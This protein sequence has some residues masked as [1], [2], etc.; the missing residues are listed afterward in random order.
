MATIVP[1]RILLL[2]EHTAALDPR[3]AKLIVELSNACIRDAKLTALMGNSQ[4]AATL[5]CGD[6]TIMMSE[7]QIAFDVRS[8]ERVVYDMP[9]LLRLFERTKG[10]PPDDDALLL[11]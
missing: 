11:A 5:S 8:E 4:Y 6:R 3:N 7:G 10:A 9:D 2:D 1:M